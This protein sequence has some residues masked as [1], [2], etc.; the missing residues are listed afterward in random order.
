MPSAPPSHFRGAAPLVSSTRPG[1][2]EAHGIL[3][4][5]NIGKK[6]DLVVS[7]GVGFVCV[8]GEGGVC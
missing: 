2:G 8:W 3:A 6:H 4:R 5:V 7:V 1:E